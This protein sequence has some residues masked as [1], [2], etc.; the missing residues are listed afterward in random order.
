[1]PET[2]LSKW[3][4]IKYLDWQRQFGR[5][6]VTDFSVWLGLEN[7]TVNHWLNGARSRPS[8][9]H[10]DVLA[11]KLG[12]LTVYELVG[13]PTPDPLLLRVKMEWDTLPEETRAFIDR[14]L[15]KAEEELEQG[16]EVL[17]PFTPKTMG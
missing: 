15:E 5:K 7:A 2:P 14:E 8:A 4:N 12:D 6:P 13:Y 17:K 3:L 9:E 10:I 16:T 1:M 11:Y